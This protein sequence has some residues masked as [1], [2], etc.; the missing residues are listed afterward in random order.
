MRAPSGM[1]DPSAPV[2]CCLFPQQFAGGSPTLMTLYSRSIRKTSG[3]VAARIP[4]T[5]GNLRHLLVLKVHVG[6]EG[7]SFRQALSPA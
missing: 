1:N 6:R 4:R 2:N 3:K 7:R 5:S